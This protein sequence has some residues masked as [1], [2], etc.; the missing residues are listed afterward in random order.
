MKKLRGTSA[1]R[2]EPPEP[3]APAVPP[4]LEDGV[5]LEANPKD[6]GLML[7]VIFPV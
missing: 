3:L 1:K 7:P 2:D 4:V 5:V 6:V